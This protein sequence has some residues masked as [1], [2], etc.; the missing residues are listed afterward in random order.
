MLKKLAFA[1]MFCALSFGASAQGDLKFGHINTE[2]L[3][4]VMPEKI[5]AEKKLDGISKNY[6][7]E[8]VKMQ[9]EFKKKYTEFMAAAD[10]LPEGIK[11]RRMQEVQELEQRIQN[12]QQIAMQD[13][14]KQQQDL[15]AP[16]MD[17]IRKAIQSV[18]QDNGFVYIFDL[19]SQTILFHSDKSVD[20]MPLVKTKLGL[21]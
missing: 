1:I 17:K 12:F 8:L 18:G 20:A 10:T 14:Q 5:E 19:T 6:E 21:R 2:E 9:E 16:I 15:L 4:N 11:V 7:S 13:L 3:F